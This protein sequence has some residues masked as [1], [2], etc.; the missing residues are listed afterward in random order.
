METLAV[1]EVG[2]MTTEAMEEGR[3]SLLRELSPV[4]G[5]TEWMGYMLAMRDAEMRWKQGRITY[6]D[7]SFGLSYMDLL[8][9]ALQEPPDI[10]N[11]GAMAYQKASTGKQ[12]N[13]IRRACLW[14]IQA[15]AALMSAA[16]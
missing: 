3:Q 7:E 16:E 12:R 13:A 1:R 5:S 11:W 10:I 6:G 4:V 9:Q 2:P 15:H 8:A 14:A